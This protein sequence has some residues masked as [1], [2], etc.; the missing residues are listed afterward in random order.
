MF[1][2]RGNANPQTTTAHGFNDFTL[3][4]TDEDQSTS[5]SVLFHGPTERRL[6]LTRKTINFGE[7]N[8]LEGGLGGNFCVRIVGERDD[9][10]IRSHFLDDFLYDK[11]IVQAS[12]A[13]TKFNVIVGSDEIDFDGAFRGRNKGPLVEFELGS[14]VSVEFSQ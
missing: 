13:G 14:P 3:S 11:A 8:R 10:L 4:V 7:D 12:V 1:R 5:R 6:R 9:V 2:R